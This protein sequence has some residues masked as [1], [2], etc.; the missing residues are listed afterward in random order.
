[1]LRRGEADALICG[2][3]GRYHR[4]LRH[5]LDIVGRR[6]G[7]RQLSAL[8]VLIMAR[9][10]Y[11][12]VDTHI[13]PEPS[14]EE[15]AE[16]TMLAA[17]EVRRF[18][19]APKIALLSHSNFGSSDQPS[20]RKMRAAMRLLR[21]K[22][23]LEVEGEM[24]ADAALIPDLRDELLPGNKL[25]GEANVFVMPCLDAANISFY[26]LRSLGGGCRCGPA[27]NRCR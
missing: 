13:T 21:E 1:M 7:V 9:G 6:P 18:G 8:A 22:S 14:A 25:D 17:E 19:I 2:T 26:L 16:M 3:E 27:V 24:H 23:D 10:T 5:V 12:M 20:A 11:F 15:I 4:H